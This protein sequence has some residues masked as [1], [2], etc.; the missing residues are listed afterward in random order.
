MHSK[1]HFVGSLAVGLAL[2]AVA[3][4]TVLGVPA[5]ALVPYAVV[6]GV[7]IDLDHFLI[8]WYN[9]GEPRAIRAGLAHPRRLLFDQ[10]AL[11][12]PDEISSHERLLT[13]VVIAGVLTLATWTLSPTLGLATAATLY[14]HVC[15]DLGWRVYREH[16]GT[17]ARSP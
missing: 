8:A 7:G 17:V 3:P 11:F 4:P 15:S 9:A 10:G 5:V 12:E 16:A 13:H 14:V 2:V 6:L 1:G